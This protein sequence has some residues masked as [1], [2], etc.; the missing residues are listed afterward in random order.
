MLNPSQD[1]L[2]AYTKTVYVLRMR[3]Q[4]SIGRVIFL[5]GVGGEGRGGDGRG[6]GVVIIHC[7]CNSPFDG[8]AS[9][10]R[11]KF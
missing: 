6:G 1:R 2:C 8:F 11:S 9:V 4:R 5:S 10:L 7:L 3:S